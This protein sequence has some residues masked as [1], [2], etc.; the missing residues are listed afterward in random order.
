MEQMWIEKLFLTILNMSLTGGLIILAVLVTRLLLRRAPRLFSYVLWAVVLFRLLCPISFSS[1]F[2]LLGVL[3]VPAA[4]QGRIE[5]ISQSAV[6]LTEPFP[7]QLTVIEPGM[8]EGQPVQIPA[9]NAAA[10]VKGWDIVIRICSFI[11]LSGMSAMIAYSIVT[12]VQLR[13]KLRFAVREKENIYLTERVSTPFV[14]GLFRPRIYLPAMLNEQEKGYILLH[15][16]VHIKRGDHIIKIISFLV[17]CLHWFNPLVWAAFF[18]SGKDMEMSC[19]EAV[20]R[21]IGN[22]VKKEYS[23]SLLS[24]ATGR[25][26]VGGIPLAF[27]EGDTGSRIKNVLHYKRPAVV[28]VCGAVAVCLAAAVMLM[29][30][31]DGPS[32]QDQESPQQMTD[33]SDEK[34]S[35]YGVIM[36]ME[37]EGVVRQIVMLPHG[38]VLEM[39]EAE[40]I[41]PY[42]EPGEA[43]FDGLHAG[44]L[45]QINFPKDREVDIMETYPGQ[46]GAAA[47]SIVAMSTGGFYLSKDGADRYLLGFPR[48]QQLTEAGVKEG[49]TLR[50]FR[51]G[52][53]GTQ[54][55]VASPTVLSVDEEAEIPTVW[56]YLSSEEVEIFLSE[57]GRTLGFGLEFAVTE[58]YGMTNGTYWVNVRSVAKS[59]RMIDAYVAGE[60]NSYEG[61]A[62]LA[63]A[64]DCV[65]KANF[66]MN[67]VD[68]REISFEEFADY[69][70]EGDR[71]RN[72][73][74]T[75]TFHEGLIVEA[76]LES[77]WYD[78]GIYY[79]QA[80][81]NSGYYENVMEELGEEGF[82][83]YY[84]LV[85]TESADIADAPG[86]ENIEVYTGN[87]GDGDS[88][89]V[90]FKDAEGTLLGVEDAHVSR[91]GWNNVYLGE[92]DQTA[93]ILRVYVEDRWDFGCYGYWVY[94]LGENGE[95]R[96]I[97]GSMFDFSLGDDSITTYD[98][99]L[100]KEWIS[101][102]E[103]YLENSH[104]I[105]STQEGEVRTEKVSEADKYNYESLSLKDRVLE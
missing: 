82:A 2:S 33:V 57:W 83:E 88:G 86:E 21:K 89:I 29:A 74:C 47:D 97:A 43:G 38:D 98:D 99:D 3:P 34:N 36:D 79:S 84:T 13:R 39:P 44:Q 49:D 27:G 73:T 96:Q 12:L 54:L 22:G 5:Y 100:F 15:E 45:V 80:A 18:L 10:A 104:L 90:F 72:K 71:Y 95:I 59:A 17:L 46:F 19:D 93:Y 77:I 4:E 75:L 69:I 103:P 81:V 64:E 16:Q 26:I 87:I 14:I 25:R 40:E 8:A 92:M 62:S 53:D 30:N 31:P 68:Y 58:S 24:L 37:I 11:W 65:Y 101:G 66:S 41:Y 76:V 70:G 91:A 7:G 63:F 6:N 60:Q 35:F 102:M 78:Y 50:I 28:V 56:I 51:Q 52:E 1:A 67:D 105:L 61:G 23:A 32:S 48:G 94:R 9:A 55:L 85:S 20:I 42:Y